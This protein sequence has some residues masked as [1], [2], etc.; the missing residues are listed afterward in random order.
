MYLINDLMLI[1]AVLMVPVAIAY[2]LYNTLN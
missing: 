2:I 1:G